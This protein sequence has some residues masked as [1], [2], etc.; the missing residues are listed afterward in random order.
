MGVCLC[1]GGGFFLG[2]V[3]WGGYFVVFGVLN[4]FI[5]YIIK[6]ITC[7]SFPFLMLYVTVQ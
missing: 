3:F 7:V 1:V 2:G 4:C 6:C 5:L